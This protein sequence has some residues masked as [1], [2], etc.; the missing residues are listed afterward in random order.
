M[1]AQHCAVKIA[2]SAVKQSKFMVAQDSL[3]FANTKDFHGI[4]VSISTGY[5]FCLYAAL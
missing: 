4:P 1:L 3:V 5:V 2:E